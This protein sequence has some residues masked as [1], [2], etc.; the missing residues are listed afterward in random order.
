MSPVVLSAR[1]QG[2]V[3]MFKEYRDT[4]EQIPCVADIGCDH[5]FVSIYLAQ[6]SIARK[7]IAMDVRRGPL[8][9]AQT[10]IHKFG[11]EKSVE[12]RLSDGLNELQDREADWAILAGMGG[13]L[14]IRILESG[15]KHLDSGIDLILQPQSEPEEVRSYLC[16]QN[17]EIIDEEMLIEDGKF[18][19]IIKAIKKLPTARLSDIELAFGPVLLK[20]RHPVLRE[21]LRIQLEKTGGLVC[22][23]EKV[24]TGRSLQRIE[25]LKSKLAVIRQAMSCC[26]EV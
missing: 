10:N 7:V 20:R 1:M 18:Y 21:Y 9:I 22:K 4:W 26:E 19:T 16:T 17:Y 23:L 14:M 8:E 3:D 6:N 25:E 13:P 5:A 12:T 15:K 11:L 24:N 2:I